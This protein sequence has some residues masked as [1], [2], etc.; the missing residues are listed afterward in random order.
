M[1]AA[2]AR[3]R[4]EACEEFFERY[5]CSRTSHGECDC[6]KCQGLCECEREVAVTKCPPANA[7]GSNDSWPQVVSAVLGRNQCGL[8]NPVAMGPIVRRE[9]AARKRKRGW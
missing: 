2:V 8:T 5:R 3:G 7:K 9:V 1:N 4:C 6:P